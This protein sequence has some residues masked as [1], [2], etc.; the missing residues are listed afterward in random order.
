MAERGGGGGA[1]AGGGEGEAAA[2]AAER[3]GGELRYR[4]V[5]APTGRRGHDR[6]PAA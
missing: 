5:R 6:P 4:A 1:G 3:F 2:A